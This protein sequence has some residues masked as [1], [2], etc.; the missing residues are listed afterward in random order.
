VVG[1]SG[2]LID[3][4]L[5][6]LRASLRLPRE[7]TAEILAE[8]ED[9]LREYAAAGEAL[10]MTEREA[11]EAAI[12]AF[13]QVRA[14]VRAHRRPAS[15]AS[16][17]CL[18]ACKLAAVYLLAI[19]GYWLTREHVLAPD[20]TQPAGANGSP[21][22]VS[23]AVTLAGCAVAG[24]ALLAAYLRARRSWRGRRDASEAPLGGYFQL[25]A[26]IPMLVFGPIVVIVI[27]NVAH[28]GRAFAVPALAA[29]V[30]SIVVALGYTARMARTMLR[31]G[32]D[33]RTADREAHRA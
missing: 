28:P 9:H 7:R 10:G 30:G 14:V 27:G 5:A 25:C 2:D 17:V 11:Q 16:E 4:Y 6:R 8:A 13:G 24:L 12:S 1:V 21:G 15:F 29:V 26:A 22:A 18:A 31:Q 23:A 20:G 3:E 19:L 32:R 33:A